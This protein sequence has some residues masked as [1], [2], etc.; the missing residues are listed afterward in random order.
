MVGIKYPEDPFL[1]VLLGWQTSRGRPAL[2]AYMVGMGAL[3]GFEWAEE[4]PW[5]GGRPA[6]S[7][8]KR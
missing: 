4:T 7:G 1:P 6:G 8:S 3:A 5:I 2:A